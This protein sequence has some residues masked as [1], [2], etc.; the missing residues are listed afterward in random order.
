M[1]YHLAIAVA[2][3]VGLMG[4]WIG[5][6]ALIRRESPNMPADADVLACRS[7]GAHDGCHGC[8]HYQKGTEA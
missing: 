6:Q 5:V 2:G 7:C 3:V 1:F 4:V 8:D